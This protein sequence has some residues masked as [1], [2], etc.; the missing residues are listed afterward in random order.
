MLLYTCI[1]T[2]MKQIS[3]V[4]TWVGAWVGAIPP[5]MGWAAATGQ[6]QCGKILYIY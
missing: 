1:Y 4:N 2:P 5:L 3:Q 6:L